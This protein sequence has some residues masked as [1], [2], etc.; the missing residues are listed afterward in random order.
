MMVFLL[1]PLKTKYVAAL[2]TAHHAQ[3]IQLPFLVAR[4]SRIKP[5][6]QKSSKPTIVVTGSTR[7]DA[8][9]V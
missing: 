5:I 3:W 1:V 2:P 6:R 7:T 8:Y 9:R 4:E